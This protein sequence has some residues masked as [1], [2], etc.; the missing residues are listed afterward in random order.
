M[1][2]I[3]LL[4]CVASTLHVSHTY[5]IQTT[6]QNYVKSVVKLRDHYGEMVDLRVGG[7]AM[8][9]MP[10]QHLKTAQRNKISPSLNL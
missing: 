1:Q 10:K 2:K 9:A 6:T 5:H 4:C 8:I 3:P 7:M